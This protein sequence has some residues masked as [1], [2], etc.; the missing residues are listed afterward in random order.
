MPPYPEFQPPVAPAGQ[1]LLQRRLDLLAHEKEIAVIGF[2]CQGAGALALLISV[3]LIGGYFLS[4]GPLGHE[5]PEAATI[6]GLFVLFLGT[7]FYWLGAGL[8]RFEPNRRIAAIAFGGLEL[9]LFPVGTVWGL[10]HLRLLLS[11]EAKRV[12][13]RE[14]QELIRATPEIRTFEEIKGAK[15]I[16]IVAVIAGSILLL[17][18]VQI[19]LKK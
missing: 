7:S 19:W 10:R 11:P 8:R 16:R 17:A 14:H 15:R 6:T 13:S 4:M 3:G 12:L 9:L 18:L 1:D 5:P 2:A